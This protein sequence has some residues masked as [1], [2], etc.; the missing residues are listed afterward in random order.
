MRVLKDTVRGLVRAPGFAL[1]V[2]ATLGL[3]IGANAAIYSLVDQIIFRPLPV[4]RPQ[5]LVA[6]SAPPLPFP[7]P[8][9]MVASGMRLGGNKPLIGVSYP[10]FTAIRDRMPMFQDVLAYNFLRANMLAG[11]TPVEVRG[12]LVT[13]NYF[14]MLGVRPAIGRL[15]VAADEHVAGGVATAV[16][17][18]GFWQ[19]QFGGDPTVINRVIR[20]KDAPLAIVGVAQ[21]GFSGTEVGGR[22]DIFVPLQMTD[23][24][25]GLPRFSWDSPRLNTLQMMAR[26][27]EG[28]S[29]ENA[30]QA[31]D[32]IYQQMLAERAAL[33]SRFT[34]KDLALFGRQH[35]SLLPA[36]FAGDRQAGAARTLAAVLWLLMG[37]V[38]VVLLVAA[39][40]VSNLYVSRGSARARDTAIRL[41]LG[42]TRSGLLGQRLLESVTLAL[43]A[44]AAGLLLSSWLAS[45]LPIVLGLEE[46][47][48][49]VSTAAD[50]R[51]AI[52]T[53]CVALA[54]GVL[55]WAISAIQV[56]RRAT[57]LTLGST[58]PAAHEAGGLT[59]RRVMVVAQVALSTALLCGSALLT[60]SLVGLMAVDPGF[61]IDGISTFRV[62]PAGQA[63]DVARV[64]D[65][66]TAL[67][68][69]A[70]RL[71]GVVDAS[72]T[73]N[74]LGGG[75]TWI[76]GDDRERTM[77]DATLVD[78][79]DVGSSYFGTLGIPLV[80]GREFAPTDDRG[81]PKVAILSESLARV[82]FGTRPAVGRRIAFSRADGSGPEVIQANRGVEFDIEVVGVARDVRSR[83]PRQAPPL[84]AYFS[85][86]QATSS[87][88]FDVV[89]RTAGAAPTLTEV[90]SLVRNVDPAV[91]VGSFQTLRDIVNAGMTRERVLAALAS[92][93]GALAAA[94]SVIGVLG[95]TGYS[96]TRRTREIGIRLALGAGRARVVRL[97]LVEVVALAA[98]G[99]VAGAALYVA[100]S[101]YL[102]A[103]LFELSPTDAPTIAGAVLLLAAVAI[104]AGYVPARRAAALDP[105][106]TLRTE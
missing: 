5:E 20:L 56:T 44:G 29:R 18:Y 4:V 31:A 85:Y 36:G 101:R 59:L 82:L 46:L 97:V 92:A 11:E 99:G 52:F 67:V 10:N 7:E 53:G 63:Y 8:G 13:L 14:Q 35:L 51:V 43:L 62:T 16:L 78:V 81:R 91:P 98:A 30:E 58:Q 12:L 89:V 34:A 38:V 54:A 95:L 19:R 104:G 1:S 90:Q 28:E 57:I 48:P 61:T 102:Q 9:P 24:V 96:V 86:L 70:R 22:V 83:G 65:M 68:E 77:G 15:P 84:T 21:E 106:I 41:A 2:V 49:G 39:G 47:P 17:S 100:C 88:G 25:A 66:A 37:M 73:N 45:L 3:A 103:V 76:V 75:G 94:L 87:F 69:R 42:A 80:A 6:V 64:H 50:W 40:N 72:V 79:V 32:A 23:Q 71:P 33:T 105:A 55:T 74:L 93:F 26:L 60:R 27:K